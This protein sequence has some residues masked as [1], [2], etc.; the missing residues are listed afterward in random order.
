MA[1]PISQMPAAN[2]VEDGNG[3][4]TLIAMP[5]LSAMYAPQQP[6]VLPR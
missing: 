2:V 4:Y 3:G 6:A 1:L 5:I